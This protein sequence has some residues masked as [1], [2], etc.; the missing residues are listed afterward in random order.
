MIFAGTYLTV[1][2]GRGAMLMYALR[3]HPA[4]RR[5]QRVAVWFAI[6]GVAWVA[7]ALVPA[8]Q[9]PLWTAAVLVDATIPL[10]GYPV[11]G[12]GRSTQQDLSASAAH[13]TERYAQLIIV[14]VGEL[15]LV[16]GTPANPD[17]AATGWSWSRRPRSFSPGGQRWSR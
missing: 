5:S 3:G 10:A 2:L 12:L 8:A 16:P 9:V 11:P 7:G 17:P 6:S 1:H 15:I 13:L 14:A 4:A